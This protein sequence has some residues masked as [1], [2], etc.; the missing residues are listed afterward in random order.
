MRRKSSIQI[1]SGNSI[2]LSLRTINNRNSVP[3]V[4]VCLEIFHLR[5]SN[6]SSNHGARSQDPHKDVLP[7]TADIL[8]R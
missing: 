2:G 6:F 4:S 1:E 8:V 5:I 3:D 7:L